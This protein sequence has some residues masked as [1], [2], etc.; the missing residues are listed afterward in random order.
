[1]TLLFAETVPDG[2]GSSK[3]WVVIVSIIASL[4]VLS[5]CWDCPSDDFGVVRTPSECSLT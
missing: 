4:F 5:D 3:R 2:L 1:M